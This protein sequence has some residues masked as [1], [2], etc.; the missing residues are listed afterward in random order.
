M[1]LDSTI[2]EEVAD[3]DAAGKNIFLLAARDAHYYAGLFKRMSLI[4]DVLLK[5]GNLEALIN[6]KTAKLAELEAQVDATQAKVDAVDAEIASK[7]A[8]AQATIDAESEAHA[9]RIQAAKGELSTL[10]AKVAERN[11]AYLDA[12]QK[13]RRTRETLAELRKQL[14]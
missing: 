10:D 4:R 6:E 5:A 7:R 3:L 11:T 8:A 12:D 9:E 14:G 13:V 1:S 2:V